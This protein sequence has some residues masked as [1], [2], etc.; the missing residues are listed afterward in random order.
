MSNAYTQNKTIDSLKGLLAKEPN[1]S[2]RIRLQMQIGHAYQLYNIDSS[3]PYFQ[4]VLDIAQKRKIVFL[5]LLASDAIANV[6]N[7]IGNYP[8]ALEIS[9]A[10]LR[11]EEQVHD[12]DEIFFTK[13]EI[14]WVYGNIGD[15]K[16]EL[17]YAKQLESFANSGY[18]KDQ[19]MVFEYNE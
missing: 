15:L 11:I 8:Q 17:E 19:K 3:L 4:R 14:M 10:N 18:F 16:K 1:D 12:T 6:Y 7:T 2:I 13:R 9:L 5:Q